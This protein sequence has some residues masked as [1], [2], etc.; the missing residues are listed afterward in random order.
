MP[1]LPPNQWC[2]STEGKDIYYHTAEKYNPSHNIAG[3]ESFD[4]TFLFLQ[5]RGFQDHAI[6]QCIVGFDIQ[7][8]QFVLYFETFS[9]FV[10]TGKMACQCQMAADKSWLWNIS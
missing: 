8:V 9:V 1:F 10:L 2:Q 7:Y 5:H 4:C 6:M 3:F